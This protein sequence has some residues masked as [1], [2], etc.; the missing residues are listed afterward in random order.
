MFN[1]PKGYEYVYGALLTSLNFTL[2]EK[3]NAGFF[4]QE[5][6]NDQEYH[7]THK[8]NHKSY[9]KFPNFAMELVRYNVPSRQ[10]AALANAIFMD[11]KAYL[12]SNQS[13]PELGYFFLDKSKIDRCVDRLFIF[14][15]CWMFQSKCL[16]SPLG[17]N[18]R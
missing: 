13:L 7:P 2:I 1:C 5:I 6:M 10:G 3:P 14:Y 8:S 16:T 11:L 15:L 9:L 12:C 4:F 18:L 17:Q